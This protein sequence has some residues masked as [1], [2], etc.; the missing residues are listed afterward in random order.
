MLIKKTERRRKKT[1]D[2]NLVPQSQRV[3]PKKKGKKYK[4]DKGDL[5]NKRRNRSRGGWRRKWAEQNANQEW[6]HGVNLG[7]RPLTNE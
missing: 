1:I 5:G 2:P 4:K 6:A 3:K 7:S